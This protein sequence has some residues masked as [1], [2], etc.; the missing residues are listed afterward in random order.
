L[1]SPHLCLLPLDLRHFRLPQGNSYPAH[2][3]QENGRRGCYATS[4]AV[5]KFQR[6]IPKRRLLCHDGQAFKVA[7]DVIS[8]L[9]D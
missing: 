5:D 3:Q 8:E 7:T 6:S 1:T 2:E 9:L 4:M